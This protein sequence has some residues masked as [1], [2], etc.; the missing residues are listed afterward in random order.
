MKGQYATG[1]SRPDYTVQRRRVSDDE[2]DELLAERKTPAAG[3]GTP[4]NIIRRPVP[5]PSMVSI[6]HG[7][8]PR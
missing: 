4:M 3:K 5:L 1:G 7:E 2:W 8:V 6:K